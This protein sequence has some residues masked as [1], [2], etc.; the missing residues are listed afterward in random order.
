[1]SK[2]FETIQLCRLCDSNSLQD[3]LNLGDQP[4][5]NSLY[6]SNDERPPSV[7]LRLMYCKDCSTVQ[8]LEADLSSSPT[9]KDKIRSF[10]P[11]AIIHLAW[12]D[13]P[14]FSYEKS[15]LNQD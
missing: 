15:I 1:M 7:P 12:Q 13:I 11:E 6:N 9:Y 8:W 4:P 5:A 14:D 10:C 3:I 2:I